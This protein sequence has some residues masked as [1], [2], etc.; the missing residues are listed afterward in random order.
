MFIFKSKGKKNDFS[1]M[2]E[3]Y[4]LEHH[5][6]IDVNSLGLKK[7]LN[8]V[9]LSNSFIFTIV[10]MSTL[11]INNLIIRILV[12]FVLLMPLI[13]LVYYVVSK[14]LKKKGN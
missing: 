1:K 9:A 8:I 14:F 2:M 13:Y 3:V 12:M 4:F 11:F 5:F 10:L 7:V 6:K